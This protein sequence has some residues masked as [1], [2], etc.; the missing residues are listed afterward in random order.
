[1]VTLYFGGGQNSDPQSMD[2]LDGLPEWT[3]VTLKNTILNEYYM[4]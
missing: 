1:M 4:Y 3:T 2:Y